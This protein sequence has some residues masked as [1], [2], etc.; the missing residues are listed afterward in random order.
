VY[1]RSPEVAR[2]YI[3][4]PSDLDRRVPPPPAGWR[5]LPGSGDWRLAA[6]CPSTPG[7]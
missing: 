2:D 6:L 5:S 1:P 4:D 7:G 3:L